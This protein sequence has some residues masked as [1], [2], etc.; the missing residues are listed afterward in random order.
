MTES[1]EM[2][3]FGLSDQEFKIALLRKFSNLQDDREKQFRNVS[4]K[5]N[6]KIE[7]IFKKSN[8][9]LETRNTFAEKFVR[10]SQQQNG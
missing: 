6:K 1:N 3:L 10:G 9:N 7:I 8:R 5:L 2:G 4:A